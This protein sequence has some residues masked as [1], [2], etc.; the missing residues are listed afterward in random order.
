MMLSSSSERDKKRTSKNTGIGERIQII[1]NLLNYCMLYR[2]KTSMVDKMGLDPDQVN[3]W[4]GYLFRGGFIQIGVSLKG[5]LIYKTREKGRGL[6][7]FYYSM[8]QEYLE[9]HKIMVG[10]IREDYVSSFEQ[11]TNLL[12]L[13]LS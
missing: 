6:L 10:E 1:A 12:K 13:P 4:L 9:Y 8:V 5:N 7:E 3:Y 11:G 2:E